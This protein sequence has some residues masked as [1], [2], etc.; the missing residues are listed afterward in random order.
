M[1][2]ARAALLLTLSWLL[3]G[4]IDDSSSVTGIPSITLLSADPATFLGAVRCGVPGGT[5][6]YVVSFRDVGPL[7][8]EQTWLPSSTPTP[9]NQLVSF[10][11]LPPPNDTRPPSLI[12]LEYYVAEIDGYDRDDIVPGADEPG[13]AL[14]RRMVDPVTA[15]LVPPR[16]ITGCGRYV[17]PPTDD[18]GSPADGGSNPF[19]F[20]TQVLGSV[21]VFLHG[22]R[23]FET[24]VP[25]DAG[26]DGESSDGK[27]APA[28][29]LQ[30][31]GAR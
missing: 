27:P 5:E 9:C 13:Q 8:Q 6:R 11:P 18:A 16:W 21:E 29:A 30:G 2:L 19:D 28:P 7:T 10:S 17:G 31:Q 3:A 15:Q 22:C 23:P 24:D 12:V 25:A 1:V 20:P 4:C 26:G 14:G